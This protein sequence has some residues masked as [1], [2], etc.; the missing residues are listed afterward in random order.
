M[1][2]GAAPEGTVDVAWDGRD[3][4]GIVQPDGQYTIRVTAADLSGKTVDVEQ[5]SSGVV[6]GISFEN[7]VPELLLGDEHLKLSEVVQ[8][9]ERNTP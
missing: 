8:V 9:N 6:T 1:Q 7:G 4:Q 5:R 2:L 3:D